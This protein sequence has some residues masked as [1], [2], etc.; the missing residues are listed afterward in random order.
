VEVFIYKKNDY[1]DKRNDEGERVTIN[2]G[3]NSRKSFKP[4][5][6]VPV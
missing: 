6:E 2:L 3:G 4:G 1:K 5:F